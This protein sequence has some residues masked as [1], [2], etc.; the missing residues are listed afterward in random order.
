MGLRK[1]AEKLIAQ[2]KQKNGYLVVG[3]NTGAVKRIP[4]RDL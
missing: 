3:D 2:Q 4:A 1:T